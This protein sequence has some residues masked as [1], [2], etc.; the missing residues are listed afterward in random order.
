MCGAIFEKVRARN[1]AE[2]SM[3]AEAERL[4]QSPYAASPA[5]QRLPLWMKVG[6]V[7]VLLVFGALAAYNR[8]KPVN[9]PVG[10][11]EGK[12]MVLEFWAEWC[13]P[14]KMYGPIL[15][16]VTGEYGSQITL[17]RVNVDTE[18]SV[19][20]EYGANAIPLTLVFNG[21]GKVVKKLVGAVPAETLKD[22]IE[23]AI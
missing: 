15:E 18:R 8:F 22:A 19:A 5:P 23:S 1:A 16:E 10:F 9:P 21:N 12:P 7:A 4:D 3:L 14:C 6:F 17:R 20:N 13:G 11:I 2:D